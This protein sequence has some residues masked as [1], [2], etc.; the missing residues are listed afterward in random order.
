MNDRKI[1]QS[2]ERGFGWEQLL[3]N[4]IENFISHQKIN[5]H[6]PKLTKPFKPFWILNWVSDSQMT[7]MRLNLDSN[8]NFA[9]WPT[10]GKGFICS[11][12]PE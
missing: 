4:N 2:N 5:S 10:G 12:I 8:L 1:K 6:C 11:K 3:A 7:V 9:S